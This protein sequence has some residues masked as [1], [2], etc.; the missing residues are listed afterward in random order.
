MGEEKLVNVPCVDLREPTA[1]RF[2]G[3]L[4]ED[5]LLRGDAGRSE[6]IGA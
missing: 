4:L 6:P 1:R 3:R 5:R 2:L